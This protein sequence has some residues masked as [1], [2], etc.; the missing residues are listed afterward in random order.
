[1]SHGQQRHPQEALIRSGVQSMKISASLLPG[2]QA[3]STLSN[4][5]ISKHDARNPEK[6]VLLLNF[7]SL[8]PA[9]TETKCSFWHFRFEPHTDMQLMALT[10]FMASQ[11]AIQKST[12]STRTTHSGRA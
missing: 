7:N 3:L 5:G 11:S 10:N 12:S 8:D 6:T 4:D 1:L 9:L 2:I